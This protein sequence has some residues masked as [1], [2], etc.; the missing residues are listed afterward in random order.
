MPRR[1]PALDSGST[2]DADGIA[3]IGLRVIHD[4]GIGVLDEFDLRRVDMDAVAED[5][6]RAEMPWSC[7]RCTGRRP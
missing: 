4:H 7:R 3:H 6:L 1:M 2:A 5:R